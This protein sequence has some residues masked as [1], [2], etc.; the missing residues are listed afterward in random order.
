MFRTRIPY[1]LL[2]ALSL[3]LSGCGNGPV[4][5]VFAPTASI[6]ELAVQDSGQWVLQVRIQNFSNVPHTVS[7]VSAQL[8]INGVAAGELVLS[9]SLPIGPSNAE[10]EP[11]TLRPSA[12][13][14]EAV[15]MALKAG[16][17]VEYQLSGTLTSSAPNK[18]RD[19][20]SFEGQLWPTP[21]LPGVLR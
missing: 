21:G 13:A 3:Y 8:R 14:T 18:R 12:E 5:R 7:A 17:R 6:Q 11:V 15:S 4:K 10:I 20:F 19:D 9:P 16:R 2:L 1:L